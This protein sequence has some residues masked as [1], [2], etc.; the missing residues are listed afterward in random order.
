VQKARVEL[1]IKLIG[2]VANG[3]KVISK[4]MKK[5]GANYLLPM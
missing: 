1:K 5:P 4:Q 3:I 2:G